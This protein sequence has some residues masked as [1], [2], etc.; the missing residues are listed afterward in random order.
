MDAEKQFISGDLSRSLRGYRP[1]CACDRGGKGGIESVVWAGD[2]SKLTTSS[3]RLSVRVNNFE[4]NLV[5]GPVGDVTQPPMFA[6]DPEI[7][8]EDVFLFKD[9]HRKQLLK[10][11]W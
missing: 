2:W 8:A 1:S 9:G 5:F 3:T 10:R 6:S 7:K 11:K 4:Y